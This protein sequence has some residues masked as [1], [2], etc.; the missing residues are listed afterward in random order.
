MGQ[1]DLKAQELEA[2]VREIR[3]RVQARYPE[4]EA[5]G[6]R[7]VLP[8]LLPVLHARDAAEAK[9]ASIGS[10]NPRPAGPLN[11]L[12]QFAKRQVAR[13]LGWFVRDQ[14]EFNRAILSAVEATLE[15]LNEVNRTF[16][17]VGA[18]LEEG[19][20]LRAEAVEL[21][22]IRVHWLRWRE[23]WEK[24]LVSNEIHFLRSIADMQADTEHR[25]ARMDAGYRE[26]MAVQHADFERAMRSGIDEA[27]RKLWADL[28]RVRLEY[29]RLIHN[30]LRVLRQKSAAMQGAAAP[31]DAPGQP[32]APPQTP[33]FDYTRFADRF[34]GAEEY[35]RNSQQIYIPAFADKRDVLD[36]GC[37]RGEFLDVMKQAGVNARGIDLD[38]ESVALCRAKGH[39]AEI[40]DLFVYLADQP[41]GAFDGIFAAQVVEHLPPERLPRMIELCAAKLRSGGVLVLE[42]PNPECLAIFATHFYIDPTHTRPIPPSLMVFYFEEFGLGGI[43]VR[44]L[45]PAVES[46]PAVGELPEKFREAFF[47]GL[48]YAIFGRKL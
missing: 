3:G 46:M 29:E 8:D 35:V 22:D 12:V 37:G 21:K 7:V 2:I 14:V 11:A 13:S 40:A 19:D 17:A 45:S 18:R 1:P 4:G 24:K 15:S 41:D 34:R 23:E 9:V 48:D 26:S 44:P 47:G 33:G 16:V 31:S 38:G 27:Q 28:E 32:A 25:L 20:Q 42:T 6:L 39:T 5:R 36:I 43:E 10:V 30:E